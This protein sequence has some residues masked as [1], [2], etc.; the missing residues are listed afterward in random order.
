[1][2]KSAVF[3]V[4]FIAAIAIAAYSQI[5]TNKA[6]TQADN[7]RYIYCELVNQY[8]YG[9]TS[10]FLIFGNMSTYQ[11]RFEETKNVKLQKNDMDALNY[12]SGNGWD[13][14]C[15]NVTEVTGGLETVYVLK[16]KG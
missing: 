8:R 3:V 1:M 14:V 7:G 6:T 13:L 4:L 2:K 15:K 5:G 12:M 10:I 11:N 9:E 16:R